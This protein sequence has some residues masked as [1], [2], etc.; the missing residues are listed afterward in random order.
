VAGDGVVDQDVDPP[1]E[2]IAAEIRLRNR[3][4]IAEV[5]A[6][7]NRADAAVSLNPGS[8][9]LQR[10]G[11]V[12]AVDDDIASVGGKTTDSGEAEAARRAGN[13]RTFTR[14]RS[15]HDRGRVAFNF[16]T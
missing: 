1:S 16:I 10:R 5:S 9:R 2:L 7:R 6:G 15:V 4:G 12:Q 11:V 13:Q 3:A 8:Y 14:E